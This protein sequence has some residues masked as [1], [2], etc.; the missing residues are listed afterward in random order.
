ME[1]PPNGDV[2]S[3]KS[4]ERVASF[5]A[6][7]HGLADSDLH[8]VGWKIISSG[9]RWWSW[10]GFQ[11]PIFDIDLQELKAQLDVGEPMEMDV[12]FPSSSRVADDDDPFAP[13]ELVNASGTDPGGQVDYGASPRM[14]EE[15]CIVW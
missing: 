5:N 1:A 3:G 13:R 2:S 9:G 4:W 11:F 6:T 7:R 10:C 15:M 8:D 12:Q 14:R